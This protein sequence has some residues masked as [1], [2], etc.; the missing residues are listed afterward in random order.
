MM[1][2]GRGDLVVRLRLEVPKRVSRKEK[3]L[4]RKL[5]EFERKRA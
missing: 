4:L 5:R 2:R 3:E 1:G